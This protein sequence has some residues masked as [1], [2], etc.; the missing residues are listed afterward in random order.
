MP[1]HCPCRFPA[2][3]PAVPSR[4]APPASHPVSAKGL[5]ACRGAVVVRQSWLFGVCGPGKSTSVKPKR[6]MS[7]IRSG[8]ACRSDDRIRAGRHGRGIRKRCGRSF[9]HRVETPIADA[10]VTRNLAAQSRQRQAAFPAERLVFVERYDIRVDQDRLRD[11]FRARIAIAAL[12]AE[13]SRPAVPHRSVVRRVRRHRP[14]PW[15]RTCR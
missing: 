4:G 2:A 5:R 10:L 9:G 8:R 12:E 7:R 15:Y 13:K 14:R 1:E 11:R 3:V 6:V